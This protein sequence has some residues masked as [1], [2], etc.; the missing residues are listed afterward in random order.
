MAT[1]I[2]QLAVHKTSLLRFPDRWVYTRSV[3]P[4]VSLVCFLC[5]SVSDVSCVL[6]RSVYWL[7]DLAPVRTSKT[8]FSTSLCLSVSLS[9][10]VCPGDDSFP[11]PRLLGSP[12]SVVRVLISALIVCVHLSLL[13]GFLLMLLLSVFTSLCCQGSY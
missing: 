1:R 5:P 4:T 13:S 6:R 10:A 9:L 12:L 11:L 2:E 8:T 3:F 7:D